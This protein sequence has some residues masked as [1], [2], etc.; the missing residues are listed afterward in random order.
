M[1]M[2]SEVTRQDIEDAAKR[3]VSHVRL[4]PVVRLGPILSEHWTLTLKLDQLQPTGSFKVRGA[5]NILLAHEPT[6]GVV[7]ASGGNFGKAVAYAAREIGVPAAIFVPSTSP[8]E[9]IGQIAQYG[10]DVHLIDGFYDDALA[11]S[12]EFAGNKG[13]FVAHAYDQRE[14]MA[15]QGTAGRELLEQVPDASTIVVAVGGGGLIGG[16]ASW[17]RDEARVVGVEPEG[18]PSLYEARAAGEPVTA[19]VGGVASSSLGAARIGD[20]AWIANQWIDESFLVSDEAIIEAQWW[21]W[22]NARLWVEPAAATTIAALRTGAYRPESGD[23][24]IALMSGGN[25]AVGG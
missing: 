4:T 17:V 13:S 8:E 19:A 22:D 6:R 3:I 24:V 18:C 25:V 9:K 7:A 1:G 20:H 14:V 10:A 12:Q 2:A 16:I 11:A 21:I 23:R 15:G 5:F